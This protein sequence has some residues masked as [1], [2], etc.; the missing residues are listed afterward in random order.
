MHLQH[1][2][3]VEYFIE[4]YKD[5]P[6]VTKILFFIYLTTSI[7]AEFFPW[8]FVNNH[9]LLGWNMIDSSLI[10]F[11][12]FDKF[13]SISFW[14]NLVLF[15]CYS[16]SLEV[17]Y[18]YLTSR[19]NYVFCLLIGVLII[20]F[21]SRLKPIEAYNFSQSFVFY[22]IYLYNNYKNPNGTTVFTPA[23]FVD[24][25]Y[26]I[27]LLIFV[28]AVFGNFLWTE[29]FIGLTAGYIFMKLDQVGFIRTITIF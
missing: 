11:L 29:Y 9:I 7:I 12:Y 28:E 23:L 19:K 2:T 5:L 16:K 6:I 4:W 8:V 21:L 10:S 22:I 27:I 13:L 26:M 24:N 14:Y 20:L 18:L 3:M 25:K 1:L 17:E 15:L